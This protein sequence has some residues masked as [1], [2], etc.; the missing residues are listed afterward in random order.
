MKTPFCFLAA[1]FSIAFLLAL[2]SRAAD[3]T[4]HMTAGWTF[5]PNSLAIQAGDTVTWINS[6]DSFFH[7]ATSST[8]LW[9][10]GSLDFEESATLPFDTPGTY[11]YL[12][13]VFHVVGMTGTIQVNAAPPPP[14]RALL[15]LPAVLP[16]GAFR[17]TITNLTVG[18]TN[19]I[20][21]STNLLTWTART[22]NVA[23][24]TAMNFTNGASGFRFFRSWQRP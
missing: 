2:N 18:T 3:Y 17:F 21:G 23:A 10:T 4:V 19:I 16:N 5:S 14:P 20:E 15:I 1:N 9:A 11:P 6:D 7:D 24:S 8:G 12:D 13:T 22:T